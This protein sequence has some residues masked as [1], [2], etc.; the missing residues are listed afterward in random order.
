L[1]ATRHKDVS[2]ALNSAIEWL[3]H[4]RTSRLVVT[5]LGL[6]VMIS[7]ADLLTPSDVALSVGYMMPV[8]LAATGGRRAGISVAAVTDLV[9]STTDDFHRTSPY[10]GVIV[11]FWNAGARLAVLTMIALLVAALTTKLAQETGLSRTDALT[12][13]PNGRA[14]H[15]AA[16]IEIHRMRRTGQVLTAAY[17]D[18]DNFKAV[19]D[20]LGHPAGDALLTLAARTMA[21]TLRGTDVVARMGGDEFALLLPGAT[22]ADAMT[23]LRVLHGALSDATAS[24][25]PTVGFSIGAV[26]FTEA[27]LSG[28]HLIAHADR[29]MYAV[30]QHGKNTVWAESAETPYAGPAPG[31]G[32]RRRDSDRAETH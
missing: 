25:E 26:A 16:A 23:R 12:G 21:E 4:Q 11:P 5:A 15:E 19:N 3:S 14:F 17:V 31:R 32:R 7:A 24:C 2:T 28:E 9:W 13:L 8:F 20:T 29:V 27:P 22:L 30:K 10:S 1:A 18:I 6:L